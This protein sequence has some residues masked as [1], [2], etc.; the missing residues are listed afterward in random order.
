VTERYTFTVVS[1]PGWNVPTIIRVRKFLKSALRS[2]GL[3]CVECQETTPPLPDRS[4]PED[5][6]A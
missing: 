5:P 2:W 1:V 6:T 3:R 4:T